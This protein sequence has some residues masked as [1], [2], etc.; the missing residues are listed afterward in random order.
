MQQL[1]SLGDR[2]RTKYGDTGSIT[3]RPG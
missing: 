1:Q 2:C 3:A